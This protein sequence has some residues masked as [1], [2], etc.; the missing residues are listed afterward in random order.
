[1]SANLIKARMRSGESV[2]GT[3]C[4]LPS[5]FTVDVIARSGVDFVVIDME[6]GT[7]TWETAEEMV[8]AAY[9]NG[10]QP[11]IRVGEFGENIVLHALE[12]GAN[13]IMVPNVA[14]ADIARRV[15]DAARYGPDG[16]RGLSP[17]T[18]CHNY[19]HE[20]LAQSLH[21]NNDR[22]L[23]GILVEGRQGIEDLP[24][25]A[26]VPGI[27]LIYLGTYDISQSVGRPGEIEHPEVEAQ[28]ER[29][30]RII[31]E[32]GKMAGTVSR[33]LA[34]CRRFRDM[35]FTLV[36]YVADSYAL[37]AFYRNAIAQYA[38]L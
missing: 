25:I 32:S 35:G 2:F 30:L 3:W 10:C 31:R 27:D 28:L 17:Y 14:T 4:M 29:C 8:R 11:I 19:T 21:D 38:K 37:T 6:H 36:A 15:A 5:S 23:V 34:T 16:H 24:E 9:V 33:D 7:I 13:A 1:M 18:R 22:L 12:T 26:A 20:N